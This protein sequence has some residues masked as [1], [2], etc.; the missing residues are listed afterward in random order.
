MIGSPRLPVFRPLGMLAVGI[1][2][3]AACA[4]SP[5]PVARSSADAGQAAPRSGGTLRLTWIAEP[6]NLSPK[7][8]GGSGN[9]EWQ[10]PFTST[11]TYL[12]MSRV[13]HPMIAQEIPTQAN[14]GWVIN[15]D[16]TMVT[17]Y[18]LRPNTTWHD[19]TA[20]TA[21]D[22]VFAFEVYS[23]KDLPIVKLTPETLMDRVEAPDDH[24]LIVRWK[25]PYVGANVMGYEALIPLPRHVHEAKYRANKANFGTGEEWTTGFISTG[26]FKVERWT[27]GVGILATAHAGH[28]FG[29]PK[30]DAL[31]IRFITDIRTQ[32]ANLLAGEADMISSPS[33]R[34]REAVI[35][36]DQWAASGDG[37]VKA[38]STGAPYVDWQLR[39]VPGWQRA[40]A[41]IRVRQ[42]LM[43][44]IDRD[45]LNEAINLGF[46]PV[47]H[48]FITP[49]DPLFAEVD[50][51][52]A[53]YPYDPNR[54]AA[55]LAEAGWQ[56]AAAAGLA[57][58]AAGQ[59]FD[60]EVMTT[61]SQEQQATIVSDNW[62]SAGLN[63]SIFVVPQARARDGEL[64]SNFTTARIN[65]RSIAAEN[66]VWTTDQISSPENRWTGGN[67]GGFSDAEVDRLQGIRVSSLDEGQRRQAT[68]AVLKRMTDLVAP[69]PILY[70]AEVIIARK[71]VVGP[72]GDTGEQNGLTWNIH[73]W[74]IVR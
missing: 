65:N 2:A 15:P 10:W 39:D 14:G 1:V 38:W 23:D 17:T 35:A 50:R 20:L 52:I 57:T 67:R 24:T 46:V 26:P 60:A 18:R 22:Y 61:A 59:T 5:A 44:A 43:H 45:G 21:H 9:S 54:S 69:M 47:V 19:G 3:L 53:K 41:D 29:P 55:L 34:A 37:Y 48:A 42:A 56:R 27:P 40:I 64:G 25:Q 12:D 32:V 30:I 36:R 33:A 28:A 68:I 73:E 11:L 74:E 7:F 6:D 8:I 31:D 62:K 72:V 13:P 71:Y 70:S 49:Q 63:S 51:V 66:F 58:N 16:G 4:P